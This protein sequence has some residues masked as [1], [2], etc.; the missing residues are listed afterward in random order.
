MMPYTRCLGRLLAQL[1]ALIDQMDAEQIDYRGCYDDVEQ[2]ENYLAA[3]NH[4]K[5]EFVAVRWSSDSPT[6][7]VG[8]AR[9]IVMDVRNEYARSCL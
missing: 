1:Q 7:S 9:K 8:I 2:L 6:S 3:S 5:A 4:S